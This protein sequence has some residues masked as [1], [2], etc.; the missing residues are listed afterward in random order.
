MREGEEEK[1][2]DKKKRKTNLY[3]IQICNETEIK[4]DEVDKWEIPSRKKEDLRR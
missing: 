1:K 2:W 4:G 3:I